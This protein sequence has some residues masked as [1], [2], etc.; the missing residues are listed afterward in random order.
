[1]S[2]NQVNPVSSGPS[3]GT[4]SITNAA[5]GAFTYTPFNNWYGPDSFAFDISNGTQTSNTGVVYI[6]VVQQYIPPTTSS[7]N[8]ALSVTSGSTLSGSLTNFVTNLEGN[9]I[10]Y[11]LSAPAAHGSAS[12]SST[13][14]FT[15]TPLVGYTGT[16]TFSYSVLDTTAHVTSNTSIV[17]VNVVAGVPPTI[18]WQSTGYVGIYNDYTPPN[19]QN[20]NVQLSASCSSGGVVT[21]QQGNIPLPPG[22][23]LSST[24]L[25]SGSVPPA[26]VGFTPTIYQ[27]SATASCPGAN[28]TLNTN[29][30]SLVVMPPNILS[31]SYAGP[32]SVVSGCGVAAAGATTIPGVIAGTSCPSTTLSLSAIVNP[33][34]SGPG[35]Y[36]WNQ[37]S[38]VNNA[39]VLIVGGGGG[40]AG[41]IVPSTPNI[42]GSGGGAGGYLFY[43]SEPLSNASTVAITVGA[44]GLGGALATS[45]SGATAGSPGGSSSFGNLTAQGGLG[46]VGAGAVGGAEPGTNAIPPFNIISNAGGPVVVGST[47]GGGAGADSVGFE[48]KGGLGA[49]N[50]ITGNFVTYAAGGDGGSALTATF[51]PPASISNDGN[52]GQ[53]GHVV[54]TSGAGEPGDPGV[55]IVRY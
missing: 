31:F 51:T 35:S 40:G 20:V 49:P 10:T 6:N 12:I 34:A 39:M 21:Y 8:P 44:G 25:L 23:A 26:P 2:F 30:I 36:I 7:P 32:P 50:N 14:G 42:N 24:G 54:Y 27:I 28:P 41:A 37:P 53:G 38:N 13:G 45:T 17:T 19:I 52:G 1:V 43:Q 3:H 15:Y 55:V 18:T 22:L 16:D 4:L 11:S 46:G 29:P 47:E 9:Q 33:N 48:P 5:T